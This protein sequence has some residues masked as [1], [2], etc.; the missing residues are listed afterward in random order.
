[1]M[2]P[3]SL[4]GIFLSTVLFLLPCCAFAAAPQEPVPGASQ[5]L[6]SMV[7]V[8]KSPAATAAPRRIGLANPASVHCLKAGGQLE[9]RKG[10][11]GQYGV[12]HL[13]DGRMCEEWSYFRTGACL[14]ESLK[15]K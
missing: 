8:Q 6:A 5:P 13:P 1:M 7:G 14:A 11:G 2:A 12:C 4:H 3:R 10:T 9:I 15:N